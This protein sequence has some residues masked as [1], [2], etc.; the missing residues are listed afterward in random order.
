MKNT[1]HKPWSIDTGWLEATIE[2]RYVEAKVYTEPSHFGINDGC[3]SKLS[4]GKTDKRD[5]NRNFFNQ[6]CYN[7]DRGVDFDNAPTG[8]VDKIAAACE[9]HMRA[10]YAKHSR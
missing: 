10:E 9:E 3:V 5:K 1:F 6:L 4:I 8:L 7:Y 2:G